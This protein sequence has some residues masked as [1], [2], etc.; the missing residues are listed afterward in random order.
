MPSM[1]SIHVFSPCHQSMSETELGPE[2][3]G[4]WL[5]FSAGVC[6]PRDLTPGLK[7]ASLGVLYFLLS[8]LLPS[9]RPEEA[10]FG[11]L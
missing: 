3:W 9:P 6:F 1:C 5:Q 4:A 8:C 11:G 7:P 10:L 2:S